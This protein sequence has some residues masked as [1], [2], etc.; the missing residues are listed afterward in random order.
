MAVAQ[1]TKKSGSGS[2]TTDALTTQ[3]SG[4][5]FIVAAAAQ[6]GGI[7]NAISDS[8]SNSYGSPILDIENGVGMGVKLWYCENGTGGSGHTVTNTSIVD[9]TLYFLELTGMLTSG[10]LDQSAQNT[11]GSSPYDSSSIT[12]TQA[13]ETIIGMVG[14]SGG[15]FTAGNSFTKIQEETDSGLYWP[16]CLVARDVTST[17]SYNTTFTSTD[18]SAKALLI[19]SFKAAGGGGPAPSRNLL[20]LGCG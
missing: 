3:A 1:S 2:I 8:K 10:A 6:A 7:N 12:T 15:T 5:V 17:G 13:I 11:D 16:S 9:G 4:S 18:G 14:D 19:A 20:L